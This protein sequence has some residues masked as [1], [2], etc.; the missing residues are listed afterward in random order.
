MYQTNNEGSQHAPMFRSTVVVDG[1][2]YTSPN[3]FSHRK[4]AEQ[5]VARIA[6][7]SMPQKI[8]VEEYPLI[9]EVV[10][11]MLIVFN[12]LDFVELCV[13]FF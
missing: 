1:A 5:D 4:T 9:Q 6:L 8:M 13:V 2:S 11:F 3:I 7:L 12:L 10:I